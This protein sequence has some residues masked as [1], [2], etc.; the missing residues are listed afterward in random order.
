MT[1]A[2]AAIGTIPAD[3]RD[4]LGSVASPEALAPIAAFV[5][6][7]RRTSGVFPSPGRV[8]AALEAT[9][10]SSVRAVIV[11]QDPYPTRDHAVGLAF[12]VPNDLRPLPPSL[13]N[14][15]A[16]LEADL[17]LP[18]P[19]GGSLEPWARHGVLLLNTVL[20]VR[21]GAPGS[22]RR[23]G[24][25][26]L[27][28]E[29]VVAVAAGDDPVAFLLWG[30][31]AQAKAEL[32]VDRRHI[33]LCAAHPSPLS[34]KGFLGRKPFSTANEELRQRGGQPIDW[35]LLSSDACE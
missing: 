34:A 31:R 11:G 20:T 24:W 17:G 2:Y 5:A 29:I 33:V 32:I 28:D 16:E 22:H 13:R 9:P 3:W 19:D 35:N 15:R 27:T 26:A 14:I 25:E 4:V 21:E 1:R 18:V 6:E 12:S 8:F 10:Y 7:E 23:R 30:R